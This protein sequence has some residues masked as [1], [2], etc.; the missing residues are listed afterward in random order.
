MI[1]GEYP[2]VIGGIADYTNK[3]MNTQNAKSWFLFYK[4]KWNSFLLLK[5]ILEIIKLKPDCIFLQYPAR[6]YAWSFSPYLLC[7]FFSLFTNIIFIPVLHEYSELHFIRKMQMKII[8]FTA[9]K[10]IVTNSFEMNA[11]INTNEKLKNK[12][13]I[14]KIISNAE[15]FSEQK[16][17][18]ERYYDIAYYGLISKNKGIE[19]FIDMVAKYKIS[20]PNFKFAIIGGFPNTKAFRRY[21][22][23]IIDLANEHGIET[24]I[25]KSL[26]DIAEL[27]NNIKI[28]FLPFPDGCSERRGSYIAG[29]NSGCI[30][31][32]T[33]GK[34]TTDAMMQ[35]AFFIKDNKLVLDFF[36]KVL[37]AMTD[38]DY[39]KFQKGVKDFLFREFPLSWND[40]SKSYESFYYE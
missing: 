35:S 40:I 27:L 1:T 32:T 13:K 16:A 34:Y 11:V 14:I 30:V 19:F 17:L 38:T 24:M 23:H 33:K 22:A 20:N 26:T 28:L 8:L 21:S 3:L 15:H 31:I 10:I 37:F 6:G 9:K 18:K 39:L 4:N 29:L 25:N 2:P 5:Y 7:A 12:I 36:D